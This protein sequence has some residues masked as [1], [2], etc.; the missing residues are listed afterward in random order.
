MNRTQRRAVGGASERAFHIAMAIGSGLLVIAAIGGGIGLRR[1]S[2]QY[3]T[4]L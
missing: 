2:R 4:N 1:P 3:T